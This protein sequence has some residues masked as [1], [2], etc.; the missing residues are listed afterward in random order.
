MLGLAG[1]INAVTGFDGYRP[2]SPEAMIAAAPE[3]I[4]VPARSL[5]GLGGVD[6]VVALPG[7]GD[8]PAGRARRIVAI[9]DALLLGFGPRLAEGVAGLH[10]ALARAVAPA[11]AVAPS[12]AEVGAP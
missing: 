11:A 8:T 2:L 10:A 5:P 4:L 9:D 6:G 7:I 12:A 1:A 3:V